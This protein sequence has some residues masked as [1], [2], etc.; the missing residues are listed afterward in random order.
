MALSNRVEI[1]KGLKLRLLQ[2]DVLIWMGKLPW[3]QFKTGFSLRPG[4]YSRKY[5]MSEC[6]GKIL[7]CN[8]LLSVCQCLQN[9]FDV[10]HI[11]RDSFM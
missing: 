1:E 10:L 3:G 11:T 5:G 8:I 4:L 9:M 7:S 2:Y 6:T